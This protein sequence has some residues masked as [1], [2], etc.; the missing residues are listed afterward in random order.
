MTI[1]W[2][3]EIICEDFF[4]DIVMRIRKTIDRKFLTRISYWN[5]DVVKWFDNHYKGKRSNTV[6]VIKSMIKD[7]KSLFALNV[8]LNVITKKAATEYMLWIFDRSRMSTN[9]RLEEAVSE[10]R[11]LIE[12]SYSK[13][14]IR[15]KI[16]NICDRVLPDLCCIYDSSFSKVNELFHEKERIFAI[17]NIA[18]GMLDERTCTRLVYMTLDSCSTFC[19]KEKEEKKILNKG[20]KIIKDNMS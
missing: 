15:E 3:V 8:I 12:S 19:E 9:K 7:G 16:Y 10:I 6:S 17:K 1:N 14:D 18:R 5:S 13:K 20:L 11:R 4:G 2:L